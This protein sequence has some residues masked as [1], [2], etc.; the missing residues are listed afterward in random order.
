LCAGVERANCELENGDNIDWA[1]SMC[2]KKRAED[3]SEYTQKLFRVRA[4]KI[5][6]Y[7]MRANDLNYEEWL[8]LAEIELWLET[9]QPSK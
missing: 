9:R 7:P 2:P 4:L 6:G 5:A 1:C 8:D 3:L